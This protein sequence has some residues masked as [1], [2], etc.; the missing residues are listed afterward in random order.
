MMRFITRSSVAFM[1]V[2]AACNWGTRPTD[3]APAMGPQGARVA[4]RVRGEE[5]DRV[6]ELFSV[7]SI[8][9][10]V[11]NAKLTRITW[12]R[13]AA[14]DVKQL[15]SDYDI[16]FGETVTP[17]KRAMLAPISRFPQGLS[18]DLL[19]AVL[20]ALNQSAVEEVR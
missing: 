17:W 3:L 7:D 11:R 2:A 4:V 10:M 1:C 14:M 16:S 18:G 12:P 13:L 15:G 6:G 9:V 20:S 19:R 8:G 5:S